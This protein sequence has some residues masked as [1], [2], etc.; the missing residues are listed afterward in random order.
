M[1]L[2]VCRS[3]NFAPFGHKIHIRIVWTSRIDFFLS[4]QVFFVK[5]NVTKNVLRL[6]AAT[7]EMLYFLTSNSRYFKKYKTEQI[8]CFSQKLNY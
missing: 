1:L 4:H 6:S 8:M 3:T 7:I 5:N 2:G